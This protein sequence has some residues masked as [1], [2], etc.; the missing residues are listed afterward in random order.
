MGSCGLKQRPGVSRG[1]H[2]S[3]IREFFLEKQTRV[4]RVLF[5]SSVL[6]KLI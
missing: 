2:S 5:V 3:G 4:M 1:F 6:F